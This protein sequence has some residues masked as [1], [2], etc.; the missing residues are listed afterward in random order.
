M[1]INLEQFKKILKNSSE[2][3]SA[4]D[5][6]ISANN[7]IYLRTSGVI[8][9]E[10]PEYN[11]ITE[12]DSC[13]IFE[14]LLEFLSP[15]AKLFV[16]KQIIEKFHTGFSII[17]EDLIFR[18]NVSVLAEGYYIV[19]RLIPSMPPDMSELNLFP[20][21]EKTIKSIV[22]NEQGLFLV[23][24][25]T[26]SGKTTT[27]ASIIKH[28]NST[29]KR[30]IVSF[31]DPIEYRH[32]SIKSHVVQKELGRDFLSFPLALESL[33]RE[34]PDVAYIGEIRD[35]T[36][37]NLALQIA[38]TGHLVLAT[39]HSDSPLESIQRIIGM[40]SNPEETR[41]RLSSS[42]RCSL[43]QK[44]KPYYDGEDLDD[45]GKPK[46]KRV[47]IWEMLTVTNAIRNLIASKEER[48]VA[49][50]LDNSP[51]SSSYNKVLM[52]YCNQK[53]LPF[54]VAVKFSPDKESFLSSYVKTH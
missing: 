30:N 34:D 33:L 38:E 23:V 12:E 19:M 42:L 17:S 21:T 11:I 24:G 3:Y 31:E 1:K 18:V 37:L 35:E 5:I 47:L 27:I 36:T 2:E 49:G 7:H 45:N 53:T 50:M 28:I 14:H 32:R 8:E 39:L 43:A 52:E 9:E 26:G 22:D 10:F 46:K 48:T 4:S 51:G 44:L 40:S 54:E 41:N 13:Q 6:H 16:R 25:P 15:N 20:Q 29:S